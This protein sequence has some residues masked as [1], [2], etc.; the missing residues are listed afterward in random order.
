MRHLTP[1]CLSAGI[2]GFAGCTSVVGT[3]IVTAPNQIKPFAKAASLPPAAR[4]LLGV[5][6]QF[7][8]EVG[9]PVASLAVSVVE[10]QPWQPPRGT[11]LV[12][13]GIWNRSLWMLGTARMLSEEGYR[14]V[15]VD[16]RGH[17]NSTGEWLTYGVQ[18]A[19]DLSRVIDELL[20]RNLVHG[21]LGV[22]GISYGATTA[23]HLAGIDSRVHA[24]VAVAPFSKFRDVVPDYARTVLPGVERLIS[25]TH[26]QDAIDVAG[27]RGDFNP[28]VASALDAIQ[29]TKAR[30]LIQHG[31]DDWLVPPYHALRLYEAGKNHTKLVFIPK[32]GHI[33]IWFDPSGEVAEHTRQWFLRW[34]ARSN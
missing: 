13:H 7:Q 16:L 18:E 1:L 8:V 31:T 28:D 30:I 6:Q 2:L 24:V 4:E 25:D 12:L 21:P 9:P 3:A 32:T 11:I 19:K 20:L 5:D 17:G 14:T 26:W 15:L 29:N 33:K 34:L 27:V 23:I 10:P 22:Y